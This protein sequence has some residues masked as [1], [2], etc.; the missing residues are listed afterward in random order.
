MRKA[1]A[2][3][4]ILNAHVCAQARAKEKNMNNETIQ[5]VLNYVITF[6]STGVG[7]TVLTIIIKAI[8]TAVTNVKTKKYSKLTEADKSAIVEQVKEGVLNA[9]K[10]GVSVDMDAQIDKATARR[11]TS[12]ERSQNEI[13]EQVNR[14]IDY[15][16]TVLSA[17]GDFKTISPE[18]KERIKEILAQTNKTLERVVE[19]E[20]PKVEIL[21]DNKSKTKEKTK[22]SY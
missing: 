12:V 4:E 15:Q 9:I 19:V 10:D 5:T 17:I 14:L 22:L 2:L 20:M 11:I 18:S 16:K 13:V 3:A 21:A 8:V 7:A 6:L 1:S